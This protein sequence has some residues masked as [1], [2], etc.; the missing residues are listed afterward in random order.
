MIQG[1]YPVIRC[2]L[3]QRGWVEKK[4]L[5]PS[6]TTLP[7]PQKDPDRSVMADSDTTEDGGRSLHF[8]KRPLLSPFPLVPTVSG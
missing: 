5:H 7:P 2:L 6:G 3:R 8:R 4:M 1:R